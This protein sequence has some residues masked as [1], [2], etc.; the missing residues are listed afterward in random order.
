[1]KSN[2]EILELEKTLL[3][4]EN[5]H[6]SFDYLRVSI[7]SPNRIKSW[8]ER[9]LPNGEI[10][11]EILKPETIN[12]RSH[13]PEI[14]G[15]FC[16]KIFGPIKNWKCKCGKYNG[17]ILDKI[18]DECQVEI[19]EARVRR[20]RMGYIDLT[21]PVT[22]LWYLKG[23]PNYLLILLKCINPDIK[24][25]H[26]EQIVYFKEGERIITS[27]NPLYYYF[28]LIKIIMNYK[29]LR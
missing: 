20:Y 3:K 14:N 24:I 16:E 27:D 23:V 25:S 22:H 15:L 18:C 9:I 12:F 26:L 7:A 28:Y 5:L 29:I 4:L 19:I 13:Q 17:F 8:S 1:M 21:C 10:I 2:D 11:G 6:A